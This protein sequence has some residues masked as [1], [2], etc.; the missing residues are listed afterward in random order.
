M[1]HD[2]DRSHR[3]LRE[4][5]RRSG[6]HRSLKDAAEAG[7]YHDVEMI[8]E[9]PVRSPYRLDLTVNVL[10]RT[11]ANLVDVL[12]PD[13]EYLRALDG[14]S[15]P[16]IVRV[17]QVGPGTL[18]VA[19]EGDGRDP[20]RTIERVRRILGVD[21][22]LGRFYQAAARIE[23]LNPLVLRVL[24]VKPPR[25]PTL[26]EA[27]VN[28]IVFQQVSL[29]AASAIM[30]RL[31]LSLEEPLESGGVQLYRF[32]GVE[33]AADAEDSVLQAAGLSAGK[34]ATLRRVGE[35]IRSGHCTKPCW[36]NARVPTLPPCFAESRALDRGRPLSSSC[37]GSGGSMYFPRTTPAWQETWRWSQ[38]MPHSMLARCLPSSAPSG[39]CCITTCCWPDWKRAAR[40]FRDGPVVAPQRNPGRWY[41]APLSAAADVRLGRCPTAG[42]TRTLEPSRRS[43]GQCPGY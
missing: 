7:M 11:A 37:A 20:A 43:S 39:A 12:T 14:S 36:R 31:I 38:A 41:A 9:V 15:N 18:S 23:W 32:P 5:D 2:P 13:G 40:L 29:I 33:R 30:R 34:L 10:R 1:F 16:V 17:R 26:W 42:L 27:C 6:R 8:H 19:I 22:D 24:G 25:Y 3:E 4:R 28:S 21:V 35:M